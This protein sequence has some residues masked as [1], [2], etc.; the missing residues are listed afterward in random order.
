ML[1]W[2]ALVLS[3]LPSCLILSALQ[4]M[5]DVDHKRKSSNTAPKIGEDLGAS[6]SMWKEHRVMYVHCAESDASQGRSPAGEPCEAGGSV[7]FRLTAS[8]AP[9]RVSATG[10]AYPAALLSGDW[11]PGGDRKSPWWWLLS[12]IMSSSSCTLSCFGD[13]P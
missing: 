9:S 12:S 4:A 3:P 6:D 13:T 1:Q 11:P 10:L 5:L 2:H 7:L 8:A